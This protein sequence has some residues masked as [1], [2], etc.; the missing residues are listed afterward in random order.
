MADAGLETERADVDLNCSTDSIDPD[1]VSSQQNTQ[2]DS[3]TGSHRRQAAS[4]DG[5]GDR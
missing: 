5:T 3:A 1:D 4:K 2:E